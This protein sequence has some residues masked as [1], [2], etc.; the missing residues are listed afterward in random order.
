MKKLNELQEKSERQFNELRNKTHNQREK[1]TKDIQT[2]K[3]NQ[4]EILELNSTLNKIKNVIKRINIR[5]DQ[6]EER[7]FKLEDRTFETIQPEN[8]EK[9]WKE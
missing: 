9:Q 8:N 5:I 7:I 3:N 6:S 4:T 1:F 2:L